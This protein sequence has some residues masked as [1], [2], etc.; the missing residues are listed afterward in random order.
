MILPQE[1]ESKCLKN[2]SCK[3]YA[4]SIVS[5]GGRGCLMWSGDLIDIRKLV[6]ESSRQDLYILVPASEQVYFVI[7]ELLSCI[8][9]IPDDGGSVE[10]WKSGFWNG[11]WNDG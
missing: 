8:F 11:G 4:N 10:H 6:D 2:C 5:G 3:A 9:S 7:H 1:F